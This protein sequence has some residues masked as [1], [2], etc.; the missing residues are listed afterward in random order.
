M[1]TGVFLLPVNDSTRICV[2]GM[3]LL[4][5]RKGVTMILVQT[6]KELTG[7]I[8][9]FTAAQYYIGGG[10]GY[11]PRNGLVENQYY[12]GQVL[13]G[14]RFRVLKPDRVCFISEFLSF[15]LVSKRWE[16][17]SE[18]ERSLL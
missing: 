11:P 2:I 13:E 17:L 9:Y 16:D 18:P 5:R 10:K 6:S 15:Q 1:D 14:G 4:Y 8:G 12:A 3:R 7:Y